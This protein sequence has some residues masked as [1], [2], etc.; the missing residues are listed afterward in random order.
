MGN[1][2]KYLF[3]ESSFRGEIILMDQFFDIM[4]SRKPSADKTYRGGLKTNHIEKLEDA[5]KMFFRNEGKW[6]TQN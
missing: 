6:K 5:H 3:P 2:I 1:A 4:N